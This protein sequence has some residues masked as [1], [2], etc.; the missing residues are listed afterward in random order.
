MCS[1]GPGGEA[2]NFAVTHHRHDRD[3]NVCGVAQLGEFLADDD[4]VEAAYPG[5]VCAVGPFNSRGL[6]RAVAVSRG[7]PWLIA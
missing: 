3:E 6:D 5:P 4:A 7:T 1:D 2:L